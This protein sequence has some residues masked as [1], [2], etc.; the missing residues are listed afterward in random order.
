M[1]QEKKHFGSRW[2][3]FDFHNHTPASSDYRGDKDV[4]PKQWL[5]DY[6]N[7]GIQCV[8]VTDHNSGG[9]INKL[10]EE[11]ARLKEEDLT[12]WENMTIF[13]GVELS[14]SGGVHLLAILD[15]SKETSDIDY[16]LGQVGYSGTRGDSD[17]VTSQ[18]IEGVIRAIHSVGGIACAAHIDCAKGLLVSVNDHN[19]LQ[20]IFKLLDAVEIIDPSNSLIQQHASNLDKLASI[21]GSDSPPL[22]E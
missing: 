15:P 10:K 1:T 20:S 5:T 2:W 7:N 18:G 16:I 6:L 8:V 13:P 12:T 22:S 21:L 19:T 17:S 14:C 4:T 9:W 11:L 3:K